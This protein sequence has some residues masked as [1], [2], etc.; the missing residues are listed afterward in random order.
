[1]RR[2]LSA[3]QQYVNKIPINFVGIKQISVLRE[4]SALSFRLFVFGR[5]LEADGDFSGLVSFSSGSGAPRFMAR[6]GRRGAGER[7]RA[8]AVRAC[9]TRKMLPMAPST[10]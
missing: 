5:P 9:L 1:M 3:N 8:A 2:I 10:G 7:M 4:R 6:A